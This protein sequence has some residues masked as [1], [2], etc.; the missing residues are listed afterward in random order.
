MC[1]VSH[2]LP[3][4]STAVHR[5]MSSCA[6]S[7]WC[8][9]R[10]M[11]GTPSAAGSASLLP[12]RRH[13]VRNCQAAAWEPPGAELAHCT[14]WLGPAWTCTRAPGDK[15]RDSA[16]NATWSAAPARHMALLY[17]CC[18]VA[19]GLPLTSTSSRLAP[20]PCKH[21]MMVAPGSVSPTSTSTREDVMTTTSGVSRHAETTP[22]RA[23]WPCAT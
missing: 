16:A 20:M 9:K 8:L 12:A 21:C 18:T 1:T 3:A 17:F 19:G 14:C 4:P 11:S 2:E 13:V 15:Q 22:G 7:P 23:V 5:N 10:H 6:C